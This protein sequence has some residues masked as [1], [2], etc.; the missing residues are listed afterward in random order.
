MI[1]MFWGIGTALA[2]MLMVSASLRA[3]SNSL[4][5]LRGMLEWFKANFFVLAFRV[6]LSFCFMLA[7]K[8]DPTL[9]GRILGGSNIT[10]QPA[11]AGAYAC[12]ADLLM[13]PILFHFFRIEMPKVAPVQPTDDAA[14]G[15]K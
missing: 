7:W 4:S 15:G 10:L 1:W 2:W 12:F 13:S 5:G 14:G 11:T 3:T 6:F 8:H 9:L